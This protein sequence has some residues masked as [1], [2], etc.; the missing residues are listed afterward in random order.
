MTAATI[1]RPRAKAAAPAEGVVRTARHL[2]YF[3]GSGPVAAGFIAR[4]GD[5]ERHPL[6]AVTRFGIVHVTDGGTR[7]YEADVTERDWIAFRACLNLWDWQKTAA[8]RRDERPGDRPG[9]AQ[10]AWLRFDGDRPRGFGITA[11]DV[12]VRALRTGGRE[13]CDRSP[14][15]RPSAQRTVA[16]RGACGRSQVRDDHSP[17]G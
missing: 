17:A 7:L 5:R 11:N 10:S 15:C 12:L 6:P 1:T 9:S 4:I 14:P 3:N 2:Y 8:R 13:G 16:G